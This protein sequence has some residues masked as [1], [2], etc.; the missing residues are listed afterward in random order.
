MNLNLRQKI[1]FKN[2]L[3]FI[4]LVC[5]CNSEEIKKDE[6]VI[7]FPGY[8]YHQSDGSTAVEI[9]GWIYEL[10]EHSITRKILLR[11]MQAMLGLDKTEKNSATFKQRA[12]MFL[13]DNERK[14]NITIAL[15]K[16]HYRLNKSG[17]NGH[18]QSTLFLSK[19]EA[20]ELFASSDTVTCKVVL[21]SEDN[22]TFSGSIQK[23]KPC[24]QSII[25]DIDDTIKL[26]NVLDKKALIKNTFLRPFRPVPGMAELYQKWKNKG[27]VFHYVSGSPWQ[28][29]PPIK[30]FTDTEGF[31]EGTFKLK[32]FRLKD[33]SL[34]EFINADQFKYKTTAIQKIIQKF[35]ERKFILVGDSGEKDPQVYAAVACR[36][37]HQITAVFIR[38]VGNHRN[39]PSYYQQMF[40][41][42]A[43]TWKV[44]QEADELKNFEF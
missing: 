14:K 5:S 41:K 33:R 21:P 3:F 26:S 8:A 38:E 2:L 34:I 29:Y 30:E 7:L 25:S 42:V 43:C 24:G 28:L 36:Y 12:R 9:H 27:A 37:P 20:A 16:Q 13:V 44:F 32:Y 17:P 18:F 4:L 35:P 10:E 39:D 15:G 23:I 31:P 1:A 40:S 19:K 6:D 22:R 11:S